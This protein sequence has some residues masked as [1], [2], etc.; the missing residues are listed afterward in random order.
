MRAAAGRARRVLVTRPVH[1]AKPWVEQLNLHGFEAE[2]LSLIEIAPVTAE[3]EVAALLRARQSLGKYAALMFVSGNAV[4]HFFQQKEAAARRLSSS[5]AIEKVANQVW[6]TALRFLAPGPGTAAALRLAGIAASQIDTPPMD[7]V[8]FDSQAL[9]QVVGRRAWAGEHVLVLRG[10][11][12]GAFAESQDASGR[13]WLVRQWQAAGAQVDVLSVYDR[14]APSLGAAQLAR[15][16]EAS[17]DGSVWLFSSSEA[18]ANLRNQPSLSGL[19]WG[20]ARA[21]ATHP[22]IA[23]SARAA[24]WGVVVESRPSLQ[25]ILHTLRSIE[26]GYP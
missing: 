21:V 23:A 10:H 18:V 22:R 8:Q 15:A 12:R 26:S 1:D 25:D 14:G 4:E 2:A 20:S 19:D 6:P 9:W 24:G 5:S 11:S 3:A 17:S 16:A 13:D 7:A